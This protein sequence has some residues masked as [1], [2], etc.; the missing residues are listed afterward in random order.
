MRGIKRIITVLAVCAMMPV[1]AQAAGTPGQKCAQGKNK[2]ASKKLAAK[3]KCWQ[4]AIGAGVAPDGACLT[5]AEM[6]Y[7]QSITKLETR[8]GCDYPGDGAIVEELV[9]DAVTGIAALT[10]AAP[11]V[12]CTDG[13]GGCWY[14]KDAPTCTG[15]GFSV[16]PAN[17]QCD[18]AS[19]DC[20][21]ASG[22]S[23][24]TC[25]SDSG[26]LLTFDPTVCLAGPEVPD[27]TTCAG[28]NG[29]FTSNG[30]CP[31]DG[32]ECIPLR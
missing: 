19:G 21:A 12:C 31:P 20:V 30:V 13:F 23:A 2:A 14:D 10:P 11:R 15:A 7:G 5:A 29:G 1:L 6:K 17:A 27:D 32:G 9:D 18:A 24:G 26:G 8:G 28:I 3:L 25:C 22:V 4:K 16:G